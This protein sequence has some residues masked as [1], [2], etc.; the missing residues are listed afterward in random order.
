MES[1]TPVALMLASV[2][3]IFLPKGVHAETCVLQ[4][5]LSDCELESPVAVSTFPVPLL[6]GEGA[7]LVSAL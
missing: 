4:G 6:V 1:S 7:H 3:K 2:I 5:R